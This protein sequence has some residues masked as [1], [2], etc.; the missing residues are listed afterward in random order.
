MKS[1]LT[2]SFNDLQGRRTVVKIKRKESA[3][4]EA[5]FISAASADFAVLNIITDNLMM[6]G[7]AVF[8]ISSV[9]KLSVLK[10]GDVFHKA[11]DYFG[12]SPMNSK[13]I[14]LS[15]WSSVL[16]S[17]SKE[18]EVIN[19]SFEGKYPDECYIGTLVDLDSKMFKMRLINP[20][21]IWEDELASFSLEDLTKIEVGSRYE[22]VLKSMVNRSAC[23]L[24]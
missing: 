6:D 7:F 1:T 10:K 3:F 17:C 24:N 5:G 21:G 22:N 9:T 8:S 12:F 11:V 4:S 19:C 15:S 13:E 14:H 2:S 16:R 18:W 20:K 23:K